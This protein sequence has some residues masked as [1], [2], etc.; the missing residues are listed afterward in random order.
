MKECNKRELWFLVVENVGRRIGDVEGL[1]R[2]EHG[3]ILEM[4]ADQEIG[5]SIDWKL[6][7]HSPPP[8]RNEL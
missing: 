1:T 6:E 3:L 2:R 5:M 7:V 4:L 8:E